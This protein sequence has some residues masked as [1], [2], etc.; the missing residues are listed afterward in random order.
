MARSAR[1]IR[2]G[3]LRPAIVLYDEPHPLGDDIGN[4]QSSDLTRKPDLLIIMGTSLKVHGLKKLVKEF[5]KAVH[6]T[7]A[8][9]PASEP[10]SSEEAKKPRKS[11]NPSMKG[12]VIFVNRTPPSSEWDG[13]IDFH[14]EGDTD[15]WTDRV[16]EDWKKMRPADWETQTTLTEGNV[17]KAEKHHAL[18]KNNNKSRYYAI[19]WTLVIN[20]LK[21]LAV[22]AGK[23]GRIGHDDREDVE[24]VPPHPV[25]TDKASVQGKG[26]QSK[27]SKVTEAGVGQSKTKSSR[28][29]GQKSKASHKS[30]VK[31]EQEVDFVVPQSTGSTLSSSP[32]AP[33]SPCKRQQGS[34]H[35]SD[36]ECSPSK[37]RISPVHFAMP[38]EERGLLFDVSRRLNSNTTSPDDFELGDVSMASAVGC[39]ASVIN[40]SVDIN[41]ADVEQAR[42]TYGQRAESTN[43]LF[44]LPVQLAGAKLGSEDVDD[45][46]F[47]VIEGRAPITISA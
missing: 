20:V 6:A 1:A 28:T 46:G 30:K 8:P 16:L 11:K 39:N 13:I 4:I 26:K 36:V 27:A 45:G 43:S 38:A 33:S 34:S 12:K 3:S 23:S 37:K 35:Y 2:I 44:G 21:L 41:L 32:S 5:S 7:G 29:A 25:A 14:I 19:C 22:S 24:N 31:P 18:V 42:R 10:S 9:P 40:M 15:A 17:F 47:D